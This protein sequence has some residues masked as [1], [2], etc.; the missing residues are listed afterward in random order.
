MYGPSNTWVSLVGG[1][2]NYN[3]Q[4]EWTEAGL[5]TGQDY[6]FRVRASNTFGWGDYSDEVTIRA[7]DF[8]A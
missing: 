1:D 2:S 7:D 5:T 8:P 6:K 3:T 4:L